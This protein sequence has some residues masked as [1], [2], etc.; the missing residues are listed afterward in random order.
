MDRATID[1]Y[2]P[3]FEHDEANIA[4]ALK[5]SRVAV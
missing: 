1:I 4:L 3:A 5:Q 2:R